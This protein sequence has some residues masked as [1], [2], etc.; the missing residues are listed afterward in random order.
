M[1]F[2]ALHLLVTRMTEPDMDYRTIYVATDLV[3]RES[4]E[5]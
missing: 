2:S 3:L 1:A 4:T 5:F